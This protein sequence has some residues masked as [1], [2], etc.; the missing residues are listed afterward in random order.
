MLLKSGTVSRSDKKV[1]MLPLLTALARDGDEIVREASVMGLAEWVVAGKAEVDALD[2]LEEL[3]REG[4][5]QTGKWASRVC[6]KNIVNLK[7]ADRLA[8]LLLNHPSS[9][10]RKRANRLKR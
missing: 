9:I 10:V 1:S 6:H 5:L 8:G 2:V 3:I 4:E 7:S